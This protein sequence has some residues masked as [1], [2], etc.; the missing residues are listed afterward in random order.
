MLHL[1]LQTYLR[2]LSSSLNISP[3]FFFL[4][5]FFYITGTRSNLR[6]QQPSSNIHH[7]FFLSR[8]LYT[9]SHLKIDKQPEFYPAPTTTHPACW[10]F[11]GLRAAGTSQTA[12]CGCG[13]SRPTALLH[14]PPRPTSEASFFLFTLAH[15]APMEGEVMQAPD[16]ADDVLS[17]I[18]PTGKKHLLTNHSTSCMINALSLACLWQKPCYVLYLACTFAS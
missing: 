6:Q 17:Y 2:Y 1:P 4:F 12:G 9:A 16:C 15:G 10:R 8:S 13:C 14:S 3:E 18:S 11:Y 5:F 7:P